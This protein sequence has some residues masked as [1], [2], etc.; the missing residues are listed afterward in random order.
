MVVSS[1]TDL[2]SPQA[3]P[4]PSIEGTVSTPYKM[5]L[6]AA[7][8]IEEEEE[9][10]FN[11]IFIYLFLDFDNFFFLFL[12]VT[13]SPMLYGVDTVPSIEGLV[14]PLEYYGSY[15]FTDIHRVRPSG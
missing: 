1:L 10:L 4:R 5:G 13:I 11:Y 7:R 8:K 14:L 3:K 12:R 2:N 15:G 6:I 9:D